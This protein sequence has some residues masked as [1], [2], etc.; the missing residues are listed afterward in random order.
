MADA[1]AGGGGRSPSARARAPACRPVHLNRLGHGAGFV[2][3]LLEREL[4]LSAVDALGF[5]AKEALAQHIELMAERRVLAL[6]FGELILKSGDER[7]CRREIL[8]VGGARRRRL[9]HCGI[10][11]RA[12]RHR[13]RDHHIL[14]VTRHAHTTDGDACA[15][16]T[17][18]S[19]SRSLL[20]SVTAA[21][22]VSAGH[23][24]G[25]LQPL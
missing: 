8:D 16:S 13:L 3:E 2:G 23:A 9:A 4:Q 19:N 21:P 22:S 1:P 20:R 11:R 17:P 7:A 18:E 12:R 5:L 25:T 14:W 24:N 15:R 10:L 6:A